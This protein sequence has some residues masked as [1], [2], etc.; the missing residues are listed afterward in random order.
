MSIKDQDNR[1]IVTNFNEDGIDAVVAIDTL[2]PGERDNSS[3]VTNVS[4]GSLISPYHVLTAGHVT[5]DSPKDKAKVRLG[6]DAAALSSRART[7]LLDSDFNTTKLSNL[8]SGYDGSVGG[9]DLGLITLN[10]PIG[11]ASQYIGLAA[12][13]DPQD[14]Q[15]LLVTT[16]GFPGLVDKIDFATNE[17]GS[18]NIENSTSKNTPFLIT[19]QNNVP[20]ESLQTPTG[21]VLYLTDAVEMFT[22]A[23]TIDSTDSNGEFSLDETI[24]A[25]AGQS[26][27]G[28]WTY[29]EG[30]TVP[31]LLGVYSG[32]RS[33][34]GL[35]SDNVGALITTDAYDNIVK[36]MRSSGGSNLT[37]KDLPESA[38]IGSGENDTIKVSYL[39]ERILGKEGQDTISA[40]EADDR[41]EGGA[42]YDVLKGEK[43][44]D[45]LQGDGASDFLDGGEGDKDIAIFSDE[46]TTENYKYEKITGSTFGSVDELITI[47][48]IGGTYADGKDT[49]EGIEWG[50]FKNTTVPLGNARLASTPAPRIIPLPLE[51]GELETETVKAVDTT[52]S[53]NTNDLPTPPYVSLTAPVAMLDGNVDF[54][55]NISPYKPN[56][57]YNISYILD[58]SASMDSGE[59][60]KAKNAYTDLTNYFINSGL[61][62]NINFGVVKFSRNATLYKNLTA[63]QAI[64][65]IQGLTSSPAIEGTEYDDAGYV[66]DIS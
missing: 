32:D 22:A 46:Y 42:G 2:L 12:F 17:N 4:T 5:N 16:A 20:T 24:D 35:F 33:V 58:T 21:R 15:N 45:R 48:H 43:G 57:E 64:S 44:N 59:L 14:A 50:E 63:E 23:G 65:T 8:V 53:P 13:V 60:L 34:L 55:L 6:E 38:I 19:N 56:T 66:G 10:H 31:R 30:D 25:E 54:T 29:L 62:E 52:P 1:S 41:L 27:S 61:A 40:G 9:D 11:E 49:L 7:Q 28:F 51:D 3:V 47:E 39:R 36:T 26:G 18:L 37:G